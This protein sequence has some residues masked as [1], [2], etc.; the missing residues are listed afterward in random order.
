MRK[1]L[2]A[3][4]FMSIVLS[5]NI[6]AKATTKAKIAALYAAFFDRAP[7]KRGFDDWVIKLDNGQNELK[8]IA[9]G[10][11]GH[12]TFNKTYGNMDNEE[13]IRA[14][15]RNVLGRDGDAKGI[16]DHVNGFKNGQYT[17][18]S[19]FISSFI[20][21][22]LDANLS[23]PIWNEL[24]A[25][26]IKVA[27][28]RQDLLKNKVDVAQDFMEQ[29]AE[30]TD[31]P[32]DA[33]ADPEKLAKDPSYLASIKILSGITAD[34]ATVKTAKELNGF[35]ADDPKT[36]MATL[37][38]MD[39]VSSSAIETI[40]H[41]SSSVNVDKKVYKIGDKIIITYGGRIVETL[42]KLIDLFPSAK[43]IAVKRFKIRDDN[44]SMK[45]TLTMIN[46]KNLTDMNKTEAKLKIYLKANGYNDDQEGEEY[47]ILA[48][49]AKSV[50]KFEST[51]P[52]NIK[53]DTP[54]KAYIKNLV[55]KKVFKSRGNFVVIN[56]LNKTKPVIGDLNITN[57]GNVTKDLNTTDES[58]VTK[59]LNT[60]DE[61][62]VTED[63]NTTDES[64]VTKDL[65]TTNKI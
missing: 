54:F 44:K 9:R 17:S 34:P 26:E 32:D 61:G 10:F 48:E 58:N 21:T 24:T 65:N 29:L 11:A 42:E 35:L 23:D 8:D 16:K 47:I 20:E 31:I 36:A 62:N 60:T 27:Q 38:E 2:T 28:E 13:F 63:L 3:V 43:H 59:D 52:D 5:Q 15:Y 39:A 22:A 37:S 12:P 4:I 7:D 53:L 30:E 18:R 1:L 49:S 64:N 50:G 6:S 33:V 51:I 46:D 55:T 25:E 19:N 56:D 45:P 40:F 57:E 41:R 14:V